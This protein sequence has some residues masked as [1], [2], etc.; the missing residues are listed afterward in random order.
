MLFV[1]GDSFVDAGNRPP[2]QT[3]PQWSYPYGSSDSGHHRNATGR[4]SDGLVQSDFFARIVLQGRD[5]DE[6]PPPYRLRKANEVDPSGVNFAIAGA[7][8]LLGS[9]QDDDPLSLST[10]T[11]QFRRLVN[12]GIVDEQDLDDSVALIAF[13]G[14]WDYQTATVGDNYDDVSSFL[15]YFVCLFISS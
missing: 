12:H 3:G 4:F 14:L 2:S 6:S 1:F 7:G 9:S 8:A 15:Y 11:D 10:Q 13:S 5:G